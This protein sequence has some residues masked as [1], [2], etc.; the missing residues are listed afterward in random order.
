M[1]LWCRLANPWDML[2]V[3]WEHVYYR[4]WPHYEVNPGPDAR[5]KK[6][7]GYMPQRSGEYL[8]LLPDFEPP[9][10]MPEHDGKALTTDGEYAGEGAVRHESVPVLPYY[11]GQESEASG[12][13]PSHVRPKVMGWSQV[14]AQGL[15]DDPSSPPRP[16]E[17]TGSQTAP[18]NNPDEAGPEEDAE[19]MIQAAAFLADVEA[20][21]AHD[22]HATQPSWEQPDWQGW[23]WSTQGGSWAE[24]PDPQQQQAW[25]TPGPPQAA[26]YADPSAGALEDQEASATGGQKA[27]EN[28][29]TGASTERRRFSEG[30]S[31]GADDQ[32]I[33]CA[34]S[35]PPPS[36]LLQQWRRQ[37]QR[38]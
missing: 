22:A 17:G 16:E 26:G 9:A 27:S 35:H 8:E 29:T 15:D 13:E 18:A 14:E 3:R 7:L 5:S 1:A 20:E 6:N 37:W 21:I 24:G 33:S 12:A 23:H 19:A 31:T 38:R 25:A 2:S 11:D 30:R 36:L 34:Y 4:Y 28:A 10:T 32:S